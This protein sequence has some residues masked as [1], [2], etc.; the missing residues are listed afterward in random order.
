MTTK[1]K[2][3]ELFRIPT[4]DKTEN[5][6]KFYPIIRMGRIEPFG[7]KRDPE[8]QERLLPVPEELI[9]LEMAKEHLK[10]YSLR[11]VAAWLSE[12]SGRKISHAG[13]RSRI[14][15]EQ[16]RNKEYIETKKLLEKYRKTYY[17]M[18]RLENTRLGLAEPTEE[19]MNEE[20]RE[21]VREIS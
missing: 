20:L 5:G 4:P 13:L 2:K 9:L 7:Y 10:N 11:D 16:E 14:M 18:K 21:S 1:R 6:Y 8:D 12:K 19:E 15:S 17:K 3:T